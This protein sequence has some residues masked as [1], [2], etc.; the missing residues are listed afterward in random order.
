M[1]GQRT[2]IVTASAYVTFSSIQ[3]RKKIGRAKRAYEI[4]FF[5]VALCRIYSPYPLGLF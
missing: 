2:I 1:F 4:H 3:K 5:T